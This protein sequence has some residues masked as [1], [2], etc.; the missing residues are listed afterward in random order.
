M[1]FRLPHSLWRSLT[2][3]MP[4]RESYFCACS[5][6]FQSESSISRL[7]HELIKVEVAKSPFSYRRDYRKGRF[8]VK[9]DRL[10]ASTAAFRRKSPLSLLRSSR[11]TSRTVIRRT[12]SKQLVATM[13]TV[14][15]PSSPPLLAVRYLHKG[16]L[17]MKPQ[18]YVFSLDLR[19]EMSYRY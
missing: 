4:H 15:S 9:Q 11:L 3:D 14:L 6:K 5:Q 16:N 13:Q 17:R 8:K 7:G 12:G 19:L 18:G 1:G 10:T 2:R